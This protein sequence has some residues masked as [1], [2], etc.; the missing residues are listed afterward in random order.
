MRSIHD[1][2]AVCEE[3]QLRGFQLYC[4][5]RSQL[6][7]RNVAQEPVTSSRSSHWQNAHDL[8][9][10]Q[11]LK[12]LLCIDVCHTAQDR[13]GLPTRLGPGWSCADQLRASKD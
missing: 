9:L 13:A 8:L 5:L 10:L 1:P 7:G 6:F 3:Y 2:L 4:H 12:N 11:S